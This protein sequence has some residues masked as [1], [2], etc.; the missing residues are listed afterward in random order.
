MTRN[1]AIAMKCKDCSYDELDVGTWRQQVEQ[2]EI[3]DCA[4]WAYRPK[5]RSKIPNIAH[6]VVVDVH[7]EPNTAELGVY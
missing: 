6:S 5:S 4:L 1:E 3:T 7:C 2:C